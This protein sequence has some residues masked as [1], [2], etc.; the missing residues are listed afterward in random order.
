[1]RRLLITVLTAAG[2]LVA[3]P[4][5]ASAAVTHVDVNQQLP[6]AGF[7]VAVPCTGD[8]ITFTQGTLH[9]MFH[10]TQ[11]GTSFSFTTHDQPEALKGADSSGRQYE[12]V[13]ATLT[14]GSGSLVGNQNEFTFVNIF[15]MVGLAGAPSYTVRETTH[16]TFTPSGTVT[17]GFDHLRVT[18]G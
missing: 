17:A 11:N 18:C 1:M 8:T 13:G 3:Y 9:D 4:A 2:L 12:G 14:H 6:L 10:L 5:A 15:R 7:Q 16:V